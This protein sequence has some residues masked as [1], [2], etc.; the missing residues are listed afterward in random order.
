[1]Y[2]DEI[3]TYYVE[4]GIIKSDETFVLRYIKD[5]YKY[6]SAITQGGK[7]MKTLPI[8][9]TGIAAHDMESMA[10]TIKKGTRVTITGI[11]EEQ[12]CRGYELTDD[13]GNRI[14]ETGFASII[15]DNQE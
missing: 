5:S 13:Q 3:L 1:M 9:T 10:C 4:Y 7:I 6:E 14:V 12:P 15:P 2:G 8:G 11:D